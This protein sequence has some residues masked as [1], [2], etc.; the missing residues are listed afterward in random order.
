MPDEAD[1]SVQTQ[2]RSK[3]RYTGHFETMRAAH[4]DL[5]VSKQKDCDTALG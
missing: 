1:T 4:I 2:S 3:I 5:V